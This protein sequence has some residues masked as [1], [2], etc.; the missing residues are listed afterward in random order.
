VPFIRDDGKRA[1]L[2]LCTYTL[3]ENPSLFHRV[4]ENRKQEDYG[5]CVGKYPVENE[6]DGR[7]RLCTMLSR[8]SKDLA[9]LKA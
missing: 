1:H 3:K 4:F 6:E 5:E 9:E 7:T 2:D 8:P